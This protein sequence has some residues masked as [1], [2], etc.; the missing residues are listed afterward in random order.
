MVARRLPIVVL[1]IWFSSPVAARGLGMIPP[2]EE[3]ATPSSN[4]APVVPKAVPERPS[5]D[6]LSK[7]S[8]ARRVVR[9]AW[10]DSAD[11]VPG[12]F[13]DVQ[14][15]TGVIFGGVGVAT[16]WRR[17]GERDLARTDEVSVIFV[18]H[19]AT[20][21]RQGRCVLGATPVG[22]REHRTVWVHARHVLA[23]LGLP[24]RFQSGRLAP[25]DR[26]VFTRALARVIV[27]EVVHAL[28]PEIPHQEGIMSECLTRKLLTAEHLVL[29]TA[30]ES[31]LHAALARSPFGDGP[32]EA[33]RPPA[34][35][36]YGAGVI[37]TGSGDRLLDQ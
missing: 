35:D 13:T 33:V 8:V 7:A 1:V 18:P 3:P 36:G 11:I 37:G 14:E 23:A 10:F 21:S 12:L 29:E 30:T 25:R 19:T 20:S 15:E 34:S 2:I 22:A 31:A 24:S 16:Q 26:V 5:S 4:P 9:L 28:A 32:R 6:S 17:A 27:H